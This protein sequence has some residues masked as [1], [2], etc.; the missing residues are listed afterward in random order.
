MTP[1]PLNDLRRQ[2]DSLKA[3][4]DGAV[5]AALSAGQYI[6]GPGAERFEER[7][8]AYSGARFGVGTGSG[9]D[10]V[11][12]AL[13]AVGVGPG[14]SVVTVANAGVPPVAA[15]AGAGPSRPTAP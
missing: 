13:Q 3:E 8:A 15:I 9:T 5:A 12:I 7:F 11:R 10:A 4:L 2:H 6:L 1:P 14:D